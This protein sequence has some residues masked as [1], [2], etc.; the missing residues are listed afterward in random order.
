VSDESVKDP[1]ALGLGSLAAGIGFG[2]AWMTAAQIALSLGGYRYE[3]VGFYALTAGLV[4]A[5]GIGG[6]SAWYRS[7]SLDNVWQRGVISV[8]AAIGAILVGFLAALVERF[9][10]VIGMAV[11]MLLSIGL[12]IL[13]SRWAIQGRGALAP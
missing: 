12:G 5:V 7:F 2:G 11:W 8:L 10:G 6:A 13:A 3:S 4:G 1:L 9:F